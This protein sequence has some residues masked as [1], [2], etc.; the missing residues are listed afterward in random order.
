MQQTSTTLNETVI[1]AGFGRRLAA[2]ALDYMITTAVLAIVNVMAGFLPWGF[3]FSI[4]AG[5]ALGVAYGAGFESS[6][7]QAT[8]GKMAFG[9]KVTDINGQRLKLDRALA[10]NWAM[11]VSNLTLGIGY[12]MIG[13]TKKHQGLHDKIANCLV[14]R[15]PKVLGC[16]DA[17]AT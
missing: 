7:H 12:L 1:Y 2:W 4:I 5:L 6:R 8:P 9:L 3:V 13:T 15:S 17:H 10:R 16:G 11:A 14:V